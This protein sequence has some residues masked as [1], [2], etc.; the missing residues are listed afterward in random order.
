MLIVQGYRRPLY[1]VNDAIKAR[2]IDE[3]FSVDGWTRKWTSNYSLCSTI[4]HYFFVQP[5]RQSSSDWSKVVYYFERRASC[6]TSL[7]H[8]SNKSGTSLCGT[9]WCGSIFHWG[10][11]SDFPTYMYKIRYI[12]SHWTLAFT[13]NLPVIA[14]QTW[15]FSSLC[16][17]TYIQIKK[18]LFTH[19]NM[20]KRV[21]SFYD[22][23]LVY[24][25]TI[26]WFLLVESLK[27]SLT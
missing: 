15:S 9:S 8:V 2:I 12:S 16:N 19:L 6:L 3:F 25:R 26:S 14:L 23:P 22:L 21:T 27:S 11:L 17:A 18:R 5:E 20:L 13:V 1:L 24:P 7:N 10:E 4:T